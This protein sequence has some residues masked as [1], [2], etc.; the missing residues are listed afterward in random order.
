MTTSQGTFTPGQTLIAGGSVTNLG[1]PGIATDFYVGILRPDR[2]IQFFTPTGIVVGNVTDLRSFRPLAVNVPLTRHF[3]V[4]QPSVFTHQW[5]ADD[6]RGS[7]V[8]FIV[9]VQTGAFAGGTIADDQILRVATA[10]YSFP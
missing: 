1:L 2:S 8:F 9:A 3:S 4:S 5:T 7:Y 6:Q 10:P